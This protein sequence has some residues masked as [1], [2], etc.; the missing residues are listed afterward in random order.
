MQTVNCLQCSYLLDVVILALL[1][2]ESKP[3]RAVHLIPLF[4]S[5]HQIILLLIFFGV[6]TTNLPYRETPCS[7]RTFI[8][9][10]EIFFSSNGL[11][12]KKIT[13]TFLY[14]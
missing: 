14:A 13:L 12:L 10:S 6:I 4:V 1:P 7:L 2:I 11:Y 8:K 3:K 5:L 9:E